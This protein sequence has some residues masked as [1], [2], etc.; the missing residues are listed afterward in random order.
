MKCILCGGDQTVVFYTEPKLKE[1]YYRCGTCD[2]RFVDP[3]RRL[4]SPGEK[5][6]YETHEN[7]VEDVRYQEFQRPVIALIEAKPQEKKILDFGCGAGPVIKHLLEPRGYEV[8]LYDPFFFPDRAVLEKTYD[9]I[10]AVEVAEHLYDPAAEFLLLRNLLKPGGRLGVM[11]VQPDESTDFANW[12]Y[13]RDPTHVTFYSRETLNWI[14]RHFNFSS[15]NF[16]S[17]RLAEFVA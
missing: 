11:T 5:S 13:R 12:Y 8:A 3:E 1:D 14:A 4:G 10:A 15:V 17:D 6:R 7:A 9:F 2:L 16:H